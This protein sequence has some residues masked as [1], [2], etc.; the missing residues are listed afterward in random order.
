MH[1]IRDNPTKVRDALMKALTSGSV[2][3]ENLLGTAAIL[4]GIPKIRLSA[5]QQ[6]LAFWNE[7]Q[8]EFL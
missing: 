4:A 2:D 5:D 7:V 1:Q 6:N 8:T 3:Y